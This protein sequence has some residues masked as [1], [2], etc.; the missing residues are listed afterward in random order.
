MQEIDRKEWERRQRQQRIIEKAEAVIFEK[1][2][3]DATIDEIAAAAGY[4]K[5]TIYHYF[6]DKE[7]IFL[8]IVER[9]LKILTEMLREAALSSDPVHKLAHAY[10]NFFIS[11]PAYFDLIMRY[12]SKD[13]IYYGEPRAEGYF[14]EACQKVSDEMAVIITRALEQG[15]KNGSIRSSLEPRQLMLIIWGQF[16][17]VLQIILM[18]RRHFEDVY[19]MSYEA[20]F[21]EFLKMIDTIL[22]AEL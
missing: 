13:C 5:R 18:R 11:Y 9:G 16:S 6:A 2:Y 20:L 12:E 17:G 14:R 19:G 4:T 10:F 8:A 1:G 21:S 7:E 22:A 15:Q 3:D